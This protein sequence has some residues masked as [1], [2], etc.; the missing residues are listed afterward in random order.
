MGVALPDTAPDDTAPG[1][2]S[3]TSSALPIDHTDAPANGDLGYRLRPGLQARKGG[4]P[5]DQ[6][7]PALMIQRRPDDARPL[8]LAVTDRS[9]FKPIANFPIAK[10]TADEQHEPYRD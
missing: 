7:A 2:P 6:R 9:E 5:L 10:F 1:G 3:D 4:Q 8:S